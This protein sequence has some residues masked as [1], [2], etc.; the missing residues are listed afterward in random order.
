M[1]C[2][3]VHKFGRRDVDNFNEFIEELKNA[4]CQTIGELFVFVDEC[5]RT[6]SGKLHKVMKAIL[7]N[8]VFVGF[9]G[10]PLLKQDRQSS[11]EV[12]GKYIHT[13][14]FNEAVDDDVV[15]DLVYEAR[16]VDQKITSQEK[17]D[18][19]F[20]V[21]TKGL[22]DFQK[23]ELK[24]RWGT[25]QRLLSSRS[26]LGKI[27]TDI[28]FDFNVKS[29]LSSDA[30]NAI[31]VA[32]SIYEACRYYELFQDTPLK[33]KCALITSY[34]P[35][36][37]D[38][39]TEDTGANTE[40]EKE[41][42][43]NTYV[44]LLN[45]KATEKYEDEAK[46]KFIKEPASMKLLVVVDKLLVGFDSPPCTYLYIDKSMQDHGLFQAICRVNRL[47]SDDKDFGYIVDYRDLFK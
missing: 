24:K 31:L 33:G 44:D 43:Y 45:G 13:Y 9:T 17:I 22:N 34:S 25:M 2:S 14:K 3:L 15:L 1:L 12:F 42:L 16:D 47:D 26:R 7:K 4:P 21:K 30:G 5:H 23:S 6:Q 29:R 40:T 19:W 10:T 32:G 46:A 39:T 36:A 37:K 35:A 28:I 18:Q 8:A 27:V 41:Y 11:L 38:I 20:E